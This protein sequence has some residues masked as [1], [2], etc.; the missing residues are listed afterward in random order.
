MMKRIKM[1]QEMIRD[2]VFDISISPSEA[3]WIVNEE[4]CPDRTRAES[5]ADEEIRKIWA[6]LAVGILDKRK[7]FGL[8]ENRKE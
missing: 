1:K 6:D 3:A 2:V 7:E 5:Q 4:M 8:Y